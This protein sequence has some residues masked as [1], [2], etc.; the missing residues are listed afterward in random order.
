MRMLVVGGVKA[1]MVQH[2]AAAVRSDGFI[3]GVLLIDVDL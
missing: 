2:I 1:W 3:F